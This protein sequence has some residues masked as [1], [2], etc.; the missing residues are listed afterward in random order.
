M[1]LNRNAGSS[2]VWVVNNNN[3]F[4]SDLNKLKPKRVSGVICLSTLI[5]SVNQLKRESDELRRLV[6]LLT[7]MPATSTGPGSGKAGKRSR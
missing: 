7:A 5:P 2:L 4:S 6:G 1:E 3:T